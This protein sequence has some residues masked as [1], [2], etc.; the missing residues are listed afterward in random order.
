MYLVFHY[1]FLP[2][3]KDRRDQMRELDSLRREVQSLEQANEQ[4]HLI[5]QGL[6]QL[7]EGVILHY[8]HQEGYVEKG[9]GIVL[10]PDATLPANR[11]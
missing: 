11:R 1:G 2:A 8:L 7:D 5:N 10:L 3:R 9:R 6:D 4:G